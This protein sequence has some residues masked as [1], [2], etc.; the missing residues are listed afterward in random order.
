MKKTIILVFMA[1]ALFFV[2]GCD[3]MDNPNPLDTRSATGNDLNNGLVPGE[4]TQDPNLH[5]RN[6]DGA[7][8]FDPEN[9]PAELILGTVY[10]G[11]DQYAV[12]SSER[13]KVKTAVDSLQA[14]PSVKVVLVAHTDWYGTE[15]YNLMLSDKRAVSVQTYMNSLGFEAPTRSEIL[16]RGKNGATPNVDKQSPEAK[17][18]RRVDIVK[19]PNK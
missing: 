15:E 7:Y 18:D 10:F 13:G 1:A 4:G 11:F 14:N 16:A 5:G 19:I 2:A 8:G 17:H 6:I 12:E 9:I 3:K